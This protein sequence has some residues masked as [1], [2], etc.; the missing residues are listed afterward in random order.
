[1]PALLD[2]Y[3]SSILAIPAYYVLSVLPHS[4]AIHLATNGKLVSWDNRNPRSTTLKANLKQTLDATTYARYERAEACHA[5]GM[6]NLPLFASA[7][8]LGNMAGLKRDGIYGLSGFAGLFLAIRVA[9]T[10]VYLGTTT[11]G[12]TVLRSTLWAA[13]STLCV[14]VILEAARALRNITL[15][16]A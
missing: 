3:N 2:T 13:G 16:V 10:V 9:Y 15:V 8:I 7:V 5:N 4:Y 12:P 6:E 1:M 14:R 11:N